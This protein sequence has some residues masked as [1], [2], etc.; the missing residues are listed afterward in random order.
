MDRPRS[1]SPDSRLVIDG[2]LNLDIVQRSPRT[3]Q[4]AESLLNLAEE[5]LLPIDGNIDTNVEQ[6]QT[7][8]IEEPQIEANPPAQDQTPSRPKKQTKKRKGKGRRKKHYVLK[9]RH[10]I[11]YRK[12]PKSRNENVEIDEPMI[13]DMDPPAEPVPNIDEDMDESEDEA[14]ILPEKGN[15]IEIIQNCFDCFIIFILF[16]QTPLENWNLKQK[17]LLSSECTTL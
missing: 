8:D 14:P 7:D 17:N 11:N 1:L 15:Q 16:F 9:R 13:F 3:T 6:E 10:Q 2:L 4:V 5:V 12:I